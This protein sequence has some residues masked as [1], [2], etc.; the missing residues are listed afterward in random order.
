MS[1][2]ADPAEFVIPFVLRP[3]HWLLVFPLYLV[4]AVP[5]WVLLP[6][7]FATVGLMHGL[8]RLCGREIVNGNDAI[9]L[10]DC[11]ALRL[12]CSSCP[13]TRFNP[14]AFLLVV[15]VVQT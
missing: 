7:L 14:P 2:K 10:S 15:L 8:L 9:W 1:K 12:F 3:L 4:V 13:K 11:G 5:H 6:G